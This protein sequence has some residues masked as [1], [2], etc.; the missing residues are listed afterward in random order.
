M[1]GCLL[2]ASALLA[3]LGG[4]SGADRVEQELTA[5]GTQISAVNLAEAAHRLVDRGMDIGD[6]DTSLGG[7][8]IE[9]I[10]LEYQVALAS[11]AL[12]PAAR[13]YGLSLGDRVAI[14]TAT[15]RSLPVLTADQR[16]VDAASAITEVLPPGPDIVFIR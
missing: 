12:A 4:E 7:L 3:L 9:V 10:P 11:A 16:W 5:G 13:P 8:P 15:L 14:A 1:S 6:V 2:D